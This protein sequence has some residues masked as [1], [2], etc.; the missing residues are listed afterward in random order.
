MLVFYGCGAAADGLLA[1]FL[2]DFA[3][4]LSIW[5]Y[6]GLIIG[7]DWQALAQIGS[8]SFRLLQIGSDRFRLAQIGSDWLRLVRIGS[9]WPRLAQIWVGWPILIHISNLFVLYGFGAVAD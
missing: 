1:I 4:I 9:D 3:G 7:S 8:D 6:C 2:E 5:C